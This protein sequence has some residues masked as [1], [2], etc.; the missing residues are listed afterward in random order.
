MDPCPQVASQALA[1]SHSSPPGIRV[2]P[3]DKCATGRQG[4]QG[5]V[6]NPQPGLYFGTV[7]TLA[8]YTA[9]NEIQHPAWKRLILD[10]AHR[11]EFEDILTRMFV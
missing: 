9:A 11:P 1:C 3:S 10:M 5:K 2:S 8:R 4:L 7:P 6:T